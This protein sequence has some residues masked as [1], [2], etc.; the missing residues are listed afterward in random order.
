M[1]IVIYGFF[2]TINT[3]HYGSI[4]PHSSWT[5][6][7]STDR[8]SLKD[9]SYSNWTWQ[10]KSSKYR[11]RSIQSC[12]F[13]NPYT[14]STSNVL[15]KD[16]HI[17]I[18]IYYLLL[19]L[20]LLFLLRFF[21][22]SLFFYYI[23]LLPTQH[24]IINN[25]LKRNA[26][27][28]V[29]N[30]EQESRPG[31]VYE[32]VRLCAVTEIEFHANGFGLAAIHPNCWARHGEMANLLK[33]YERGGE[34]VV[35]NSPGEGLPK[36]SDVYKFHVSYPALNGSVKSCFQRRGVMPTLPFDKRCIFQFATRTKSTFKRIHSHT[37]IGSNFFLHSGLCDKAKLATVL[38]QHC[39]EHG[40][41]PCIVPSPT[42]VGSDYTSSAKHI[43]RLSTDSE[44][45]AQAAETPWC[46]KASNVNNSLGVK[47]YPNLQALTSDLRRFL[48][49]VKDKSYLIQ[50]YI[51]NTLKYR[52]RKCH[53]RV[54][55]LVVGGGAHVYVHRDCRPRRRIGGGG[56]CDDF[57]DDRVHIT[58]HANQS[59]ADG[60]ALTLAD[61]EADAQIIGLADHLFSVV[62][63]GVRQVFGAMEGRG[64]LFLPVEN[65]FELLARIS[66]WLRRA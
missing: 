30:T 51:R 16:D 60:R 50:P 56:G 35:G 58:N 8:R 40:I 37:M 45:M 41:T 43:Y 2:L 21:F 18:I 6:K 66:W 4:P 7:S 23:I 19:L 55:V 12:P 42:M 48:A 5:K 54:N 9:T 65:S 59:K 36:P 28:T 25:N 33:G 27:F 63:N 61:L 26:N 38:Q 53:V 62:C 49:T 32:N 44:R 22:H 57:D 15:S 31:I 47:F 10:S 14:T 34:D 20:L 11:N 1:T 13:F 46:L 3:V 24:I 39:N 64:D 52:S 29:S 17:F